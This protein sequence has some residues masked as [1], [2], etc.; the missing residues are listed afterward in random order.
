[1]A[2]LINPIFMSNHRLIECVPNFSEGQDKA[3]IDQITAAIAAVSGVQLLDVD[4]G[5][6]TNR[7]VVTFVGTPE[8]VVEVAFQAIKKA[9]ELIDMRTHKGEHPR[10]GATDVCPLIPIS[11]VSMEETVMYAHQLAKRVGTELGIPVYTYEAAATRPERKNLAEIRSGEYEALPE[12]LTKP[13]WKPDYGPATFNEK[14]GA[15]VIGARD[16]LVAYNVNLN[17]TS[18]KRANSVAFDVREQGR[19]VREGD[20][21]HGKI[22]NDANGEPLRIPGTCK[23]VKAIGWFIEEYGLAQVSMNLTDI[24][25]TPLHI[26]FDAC[27]DSASKR[28]L[29]V[30]GSELV[31]MV[32]KKVLTDAGKYFL[33]KQGLSSGVAESEL[34]RIA[35]KSLGLSELG[36]FDPQQK[37]IEYKLQQPR[38]L[39]AMDLSA[40]ANETASDSPAPGGGSIAA[41]VGTLGASVATMVANL[42]ANK[43][44]W[45]SKIGAFSEWA[46]K[47]QVIKDQLLWLV[48]EDTN[49]FNA[50]M[51]AFKLPKETAEEKASR[52]AAIQAAT[53]YAVEVPLQVMRHS[54]KVFELAKAMVLEG[55]PNSV[56]DA[57]VGAICARTAVAG[58]YLN[59]KINISGLDDKD[60][61]KQFLME[62]ESIFADATLEEQAI[63]GIVNQKIQ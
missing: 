60:L 39:I 16:F 43:K 7:T 1:L 21:L 25:V 31:G 35:I 48:D 34:I 40:F 61:A 52:K 14:S 24:N 32:P 57:A 27:Q 28:G 41:Y 19:V 56:T 62:A 20:P 18:V 63:W 42:S 37:I 17:T 59:V 50:I 45:E 29:R 22:I 6:A 23:S 47:G 46:N 26:A 15:T 11:G 30:T 54:F 58:A 2:H 49:S 51:E 53:K 12:K 44:G 4:P 33:E 5:F 13:E 9:A 10:M 36:T 55:N 3:T 38:K 8:L